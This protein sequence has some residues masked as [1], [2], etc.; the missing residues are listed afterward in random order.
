[1][2]YKP[3]PSLKSNK[4]S[5]LKTVSSAC[6]WEN[7][8]EVKAGFEGIPPSGRSGGPKAWIAVPNKPALTSLTISHQAPAHGRAG[9]LNPW[10]GVQLSGVYLALRITNQASAL[11]AMPSGGSDRPHLQ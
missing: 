7:V 10:M 8:K 4:E 9:W 6:P 1:M 11:R 2:I 5:F 3:S